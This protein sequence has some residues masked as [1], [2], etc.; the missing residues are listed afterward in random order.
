[1]G[2]C[3]PRLTRSPYS[4]RS[5]SASVLSAGGHPPRSPQEVGGGDKREGGGQEKTSFNKYLV[6]LSQIKKMKTKLNKNY[7]TALSILLKTIDGARAASI[8]VII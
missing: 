4:P 8:F 7:F 1:M 6:K 2:L 5:P 3:Y